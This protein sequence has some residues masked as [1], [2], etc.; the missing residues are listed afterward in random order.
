MGKSNLLH[1]IRLV[2]DPAL[3]DSMRQLR[4]EDFWDGLPKPL[5]KD[6][7]IEISVELTE[8][9]GDPKQLTLLGDHLVSPDPMV[10]RLTYVFGPLHSEGDDAPTPSDYDWI[11]Y[12]GGREASHVESEVRRRLPL[13]FLAALR[14]AEGD[15]G[16]WRRSPLRPLLDRAATQIDRATLEGIAAAVTEVTKSV[17]DTNAIG[18]LSN[19]IKQR[20]H[21]IGGSSQTLETSLGFSPTDPERLLRT[22]RIFID[23]GRRS[24][25]EASL[26]SANVLYLAL[27]LLEIEHLVE[28][29]NRHH[30]F[31][32][33]EEPEAHLHPYLQRL[34]YRDVLRRRDH[35]EGEKEN[36][37]ERRTILLT[38]HSPH[39]VSVSPLESLVSLRRVANYTEASSAADLAF[40]PLDRADI[41][42]YLDVSR[43]E[44]LFARGVLLVEGDAEV[45]MVPTL[46]RLMGKDLDQLGIVVC[47]ISGT[48][49]APY[50][51]LLK[52]LN[53]PFA[54]LTDRDPT[55]DSDGGVLRVKKLLREI[56]SAKFLEKFPTEEDQ[57]GLARKRGLFLNEHC[58]EVD[59]FKAGLHKKMCKVIEVLTTNGAAKTRAQQWAV[60]P[61][62]IDVVR[63]LK[64]ITAIGKGRYAQRLAGTLTKDIC[65]PYIKEAIEYVAKKC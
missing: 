58:L 38:T 19:S 13:E 32:A 30:T 33:I 4:M 35:Q 63:F 56:V 12:G 21:E 29:G 9:E 1:A 55:Q 24:I 62:S 44:I 3:P 40:D 18:E 60:S 22:L 41:E 28:E 6:D 48:H 42:R 43:G 39:I 52:G 2:L 17:T 49:F 46:A 20:L 37:E 14:D 31:L 45:Y 10:A 65:P 27:K 64:D 23:E 7:R 15:L 34:V 54:V 25:G 51:R 61:E 26:G 57:F 47:S 8:F 11:I 16:N 5:S 53:I 36:V 59:L 50:I